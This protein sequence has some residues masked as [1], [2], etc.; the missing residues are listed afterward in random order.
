ME[1]D[2][3]GQYR[4]KCFDNGKISPSSSIINSL[5][6]IT[7]NKE[8]LYTLDLSDTL[9][10]GEHYDILFEVIVA[11][12]R[13]N[14]IIANKGDAYIREAAHLC[15]HKYLKLYHSDNSNPSCIQ[16]LDFS[17]NYFCL[18]DQANPL[19]NFNDVLKYLKSLNTLILKWCSL[20]NN[21]DYLPI[22]F[23]NLSELPIEHLDLSNNYLNDNCMM[24]FIDHFSSNTLKVLNISSNYI[25][26]NGIQALLDKIHCYPA[27]E[28]I[29]FTGNSFSDP[30]IKKEIIDRINSNRKRREK[31]EM[32]EKLAI[33]TQKRRLE[34]ESEMKVVND[35]LSSR[36]VTF[37]SLIT[38]LRNQLKKEQEEKH[39]LAHEIDEMRIEIGN[40]KR[41][42]NK[43]LDEIELIERDKGKLMSEINVLK[44]S[45]QQLN[46][47]LQKHKVDA[48]IAKKELNDQILILEERNKE[49]ITSK[50]VDLQ[51]QKDKHEKILLEHQA[52]LETI[53]IQQN[54]MEQELERLQNE[55]DI[56]MTENIAL[57]QRSN[58]DLENLEK[59]W[60]QK[61]DNEINRLKLERDLSKETLS[62]KDIDLQALTERI[63]DLGSQLNEGQTRIHSLEETLDDKKREINRL[64]DDCG[65]FK[66]RF[67]SKDTDFESQRREIESLKLEF[68]SR[69][70][71]F[72]EE[73]NDLKNKLRD[74]N[75]QKIQLNNKCSTLMTDNQRLNRIVEQYLESLRQIHSLSD[76]GMPRQHD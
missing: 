60:N 12:N 5:Q 44:H 69:E 45:E 54:A 24:L 18:G 25:N 42:N 11:S 15:F 9:I 32:E 61:Y 6:N 10:F 19:S 76:L 66:R 2:F 48:E 1:Y 36:I 34:I 59:A 56:K 3:V 30:K 17:R 37:E 8:G 27:L 4:Q 16:Y 58:V 7:L 49:L 23:N 55:L 14:R 20:G 38:E 40:Q 28:T 47:V 26:V 64:T 39:Q 50:Q 13:I 65:S 72:N 70:L 52:D 46:E 51:I 62:R 29:E 53:M 21:I 22:F 71:R 57:K 67:D 31:V 73:A 74:L 68:Q 35:T 75:T 33:E 63:R 43:M 41:V